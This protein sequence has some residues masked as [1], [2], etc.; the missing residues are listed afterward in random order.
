MSRRHAFTRDPFPSTRAL[1]S[2]LALLVALAALLPTSVAAQRDP[3]GAA[4]SGFRW[5]V[6][7]YRDAAGKLVAVPTGVG[8]TLTMLSGR[9][10]GDAACSTYDEGTYNRADNVITFFDREV[11][12]FECDPESQAFDDAFYAALDRTASLDVAASILTFFDEVN[13]P[14][15]KLTR[16]RIDDD[17]TVARWQV[18]RV[19]SADGSIAPVLQG[20]DAWIEFLRGGRIVGSDG[21][22]SF[23]GS[24]AIN[25]QTLTVSDVRAR[26]DCPTDAAE[27]QAEQIVQNLAAIN[28]FAVLP[29]AMTLGDG[30]G[31]T[32]LALVPD[33][34]LGGRTWTPT[35]IRAEDGTLQW[36]G[37]PLSTSTVKVFG[38]RVQG[39]TICGRFFSGT[40]L[41]SGL[42]L[43][44]TPELEGNACK[45]KRISQIETDFVEALKATSSLALRG[46]DLEFRD[47]DG[48]A[49][50]RLRPQPPLVGP[51]WVLTGIEREDRTPVGEPGDWPTAEFFDPEL[52]SMT[53]TTGASDASGANG[54][55]ASYVT[56]AASRI[57]IADVEP[58]GTA[59]NNARKQSRR[60]CKQEQ[61]FLT[62]LE[63]ADGYVVEDE[64]L[65][66]LVGRKARLYFTPE[67][68]L[69]AAE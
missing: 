22:G 29:T 13:E 45:N 50:V 15:L 32:R 12:R 53:G 44:M 52:E 59:C 65:R 19:G 28:D 48:N 41:T 38:N 24:Y 55:L 5:Q 9:Y 40:S 57:V 58:F 18:A 27:A 54:Y 1:A 31:Q 62:L 25:Q 49:R 7:E 23:Y 46:S 39:R 11:E 14:L 21:C 6:L 61:R 3:Y 35:A 63:R 10:F 64:R 37:E 34:D 4:D 8:A 17:P 30:E 42:A 68:S 36:E 20:L 2:L 69:P 66:L 43:S 51:T 56:P 16:A 67:R 26:L 33:I 47:V 60:P